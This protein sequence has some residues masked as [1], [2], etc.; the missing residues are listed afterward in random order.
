MFK[1][2][3]LQRNLQAGLDDQA[4]DI[5][6]ILVNLEDMTPEDLNYAISRFIVEARKVNGD[7]Y[8]GTTLKELVMM[9]Q[10]H[11][12]TLGKTYK[13]I[14]TDFMQVQNTLDSTMKARARKGVVRAERQAEVI[15]TEEEEQLWS[16][17]ILG[18]DT[19]RK[20]LHT[21]VYLIG[22]NYALR[23]GQ[24]HRS[25]RFGV[26]NKSQLRLLVNDKGEHYLRYTEDS[27]KANQGG[28]KHQSVDRKTVD[29]YEN[30][31]NPDRCI[32]EIFRRYVSHCPT[33]SRPVGLYL[34][35]LD[36]PSSNVWFAC[37]V[38][39]RQKLAGIVGSICK[40]A[41]F[42]GYRSNHSLRATAAT[43]LYNAEVDEQLIGLV[44]GHRSSAIQKYKRTT[45]KQKRKCSSIIQGHSG[46]AS[47]GEPAEKKTETT[48]S[49]TPRVHVVVNVNVKD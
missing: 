30:R 11:F 33:K 26:A 42:E 7:E 9:L 29:A 48:T 49:S 19:P 20:L 40:E 16:R 13:F 2:W 36:K 5:V 3:Q 32:V 35:P 37:Q 6:P 8:P 46:E 10:L 15:T 21:L 18:S 39:G 25:L 38:V 24:E 34:R 28:L 43:R 17:G 31:D 41:G 4:A 23:A 22:L 44:T 12:E 45:E 47:S 27:S 14:S 1:D